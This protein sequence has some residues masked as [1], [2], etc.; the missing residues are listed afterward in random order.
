M[1]VLF[2]EEF[3]KLFFYSPTASHADHSSLK[4]MGWLQR[5]EI[6]SCKSAS[7]NNKLLDPQINLLK[8]IEALCKPYAACFL[9]VITVPTEV[10]ATISNGSRGR[11]WHVAF[12]SILEG[13]WYLFDSFQYFASFEAFL[14]LSLCKYI[15]CEEKS[16][17]EELLLVTI[18]NQTVSYNSQDFLEDRMGLDVA[19]WTYPQAN[20]HNSYTCILSSS[21]SLGWGPSFWLSRCKVQESQTRNNPEGPRTLAFLAVGNVFCGGLSHLQKPKV[22]FGRLDQAKA[23]GRAKHFLGRVHSSCYL[24]EYAFAWY[25]VWGAL[26]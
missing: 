15:L 11:A 16:F 18:A 13:V 21:I 17:W 7:L 8:T 6:S 20:L 19:C 1:S 25:P 2:G 22:Y 9:W 23:S 14:G 10:V 26:R 12:W 4:W 5:L 24:L 3:P